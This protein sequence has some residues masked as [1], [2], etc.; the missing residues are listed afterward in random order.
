MGISSVSNKDRLWTKKKDPQ[1]FF[2]WPT[3]VQEDASERWHYFPDISIIIGTISC[4]CLFQ[5]D[6]TEVLSYTTLQNI[7]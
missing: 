5:N 2:S 6:I 7:T 4:V 1:F 3:F